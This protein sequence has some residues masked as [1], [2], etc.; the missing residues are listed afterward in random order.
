MSQ[1]VFIGGKIPFEV[2]KWVMDKYES[3]TIALNTVIV[4]AMNAEN[5]SENHDNHFSPLP[6]KAHYNQV[7]FEI[8]H[9]LLTDAKE[10]MQFMEI[11]GINELGLLAFQSFIQQRSENAI[12]Q[13]LGFDLVSATENE[14]LIAARK[15]I[16]DL[17]DE[18]HKQQ[19]K[20]LKLENQ[21]ST[22]DNQLTDAL[23]QLSKI[24][25]NQLTNTDNQLTTKEDNQLT[26]KYEN[27]VEELDSQKIEYSHLKNKY[28]KLENLHASTQKNYEAKIADLTNKEFPSE[29]LLPILV[30]NTAKLIMDYEDYT[31]SI[32]RKLRVR[33]KQGLVAEFVSPELLP[34]F[35]LPLSQ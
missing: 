17:L 4:D 18:A 19:L 34:Y 21:L 12:E 11:E 6:Q 35:P 5:L 26:E 27:L 31:N 22:T 8:D 25:D 23:N 14:E 33:T 32:G 2:H 3:A 16:Q 30:G 28:D 29:K 13:S 24:T 7:Q 9:H 10:L 1:L 20:I 15:Q